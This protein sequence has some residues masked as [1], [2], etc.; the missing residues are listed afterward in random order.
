MH[1]TGQ[2]KV[3][4]HRV[5]HRPVNNVVLRHLNDGKLIGIFPEGTR[6]PDSGK[7]LRAFTGVVKY[8]AKAKVPVI[9]VGIKGSYVM[10]G[11]P[12]F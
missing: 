1:V 2:I 9:P 6:S 11:Y 3:E 10:D 7:M 8:A 4:R 5:D 12:R